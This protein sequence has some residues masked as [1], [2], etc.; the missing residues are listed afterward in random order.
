[1]IVMLRAF[2]AVFIFFTPYSAFAQTTAAAPPA[3]QSQ[4]QLLSA[5]QLDALVSPIALYPDTLLSLVLIASTY[6]LEVVQADQWVNAN[7]NLQG[8]PLKSALDKQRWDESI[9]SLAATPD[10]LDMMSAKLDWTQKL[11]DAVLAQQ[12]DVMDAVQRLR[13]RRKPRTSSPRPSADGH[14]AKS[15]WQ[16]EYRHRA[17]QPETIYVPYYDPSVVYGAWP[18]PDYPPI[19]DT[20]GLYRRRDPRDRAGFRHR[21][22]ARAMGLGRYRWG[23]GFNWGGRNIKSI[24]FAHG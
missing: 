18:Y 13:K 21:L 24:R 2:A 1:M 8:D 5:G 23:G 17:D 9:K 22:C 3:D 6:P 4:Q 12:P 20:A 11:G 10:V 14:N 7:K 19:M 16:A 15:G